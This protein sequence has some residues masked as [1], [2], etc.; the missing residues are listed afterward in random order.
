MQV[1]QFEKWLRAKRL[2]RR[3]IDSCLSTCRRLEHY[4]GDLD[5]H[6]DSDGMRRLFA[7]LAYSTDDERR[8]ASPRHQVPILGNV[9]NGTATLKSGATLYHDF[10]RS[11]DNGDEPAE[12]LRARSRQRRPQLRLVAQQT[13]ADSL[14][15][16]QAREDDFAAMIDAGGS[17]RVEFKST[18]RRNIHTGENDDRMRDAV[19]KTIAGFLNSRGGTLFIGVKDDGAVHNVVDVDEFD[20]EDKMNQHLAHIVNSRMGKSVWAAIR[21][22]FKNVHGARVLVVRCDRV[23]SPVY[24]KERFYIRTTTTTE[25]LTVKDGYEYIKRH[26]P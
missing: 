16:P 12:L 10:R 9:R 21:P 23:S 18:L 1:G 19:V 17:D 14:P 3:T 22:E 25:E 7:D 24:V 26:F 6:F 11:Q 8:G 15:V 5:E 20:S 13:K 4:E 2:S